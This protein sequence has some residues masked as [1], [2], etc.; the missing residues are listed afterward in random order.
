MMR[1]LPHLLT[2]T[3]LAVSFTL[4]FAQEGVLKRYPA[5]DG[6]PLTME[7]VILD[8]S[9]QPANPYARWTSDTTYAVLEGREWQE[10]NLAGAKVAGNIPKSALPEIP[11]VPDNRSKL[12]PTSAA[13][14]LSWWTKRTEMFSS[15]A[16]RCT[17]SSRATSAS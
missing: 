7:K 15:S 10:Y 6:A 14:F 5:H 9:L 12:S 3:L 13:P 2:V 1:P 4:S 8:R 17:G 11:I 16:M